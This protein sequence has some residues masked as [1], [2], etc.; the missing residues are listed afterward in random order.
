[1]IENLS[2][3]IQNIGTVLGDQRVAEQT[4][5]LALNAPE[6]HGR[7]SRQGLCGGGR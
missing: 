2:A 4:N 1:L 5:L 3:E 6:A 7:V